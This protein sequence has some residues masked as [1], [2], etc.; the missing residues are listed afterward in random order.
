MSIA[1]SCLNNTMLQQHWSIALILNYP[2][3]TRLCAVRQF[4]SNLVANPAFWE[5]QPYSRLDHLIL[6]V[7]RRSSTKSCSHQYR[8]PVKLSRAHRGLSNRTLPQGSWWSTAIWAHLNWR[9]I[10]SGTSVGLLAV[11]ASSFLKGAKKQTASIYAIK[12]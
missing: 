9:P 3:K 7:Q 6:S 5:G 10:S 2:P 8:F 11:L 12:V 1:A 4:P